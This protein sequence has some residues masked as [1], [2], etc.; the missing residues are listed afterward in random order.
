VFA[1]ESLSLA[2]ED[3]SNSASVRKACEFLLSKQMDDG[4]WGESFKSCETETYVHNEISQVV[5]TAWAV[6]TLITA[7]FPD[8]EPIRRGCKQIMA[9]QL[10]DGSWAQESIEGIFNKV[11]FSAVAGAFTARDQPHADPRLP[12]CHLHLFPQNAAISYPNFVGHGFSV[13][14]L[15]SWVDC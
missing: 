8:P 7:K 2:G 3:Y 1:I 4:G 13:W 14:L 5:N 9:R 11:C 12:L 10:S 6:L 15:T